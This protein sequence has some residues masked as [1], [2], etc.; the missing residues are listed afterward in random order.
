[1][2]DCLAIVP[3]R[4]GSTELRRKNLLPIGGVP[5]VL[6][7]AQAAEDA[8]CRVVVSTDD[9]EI[10]STANGSAVAN[11]SVVTSETWKD[12]RSAPGSILCE[13]RL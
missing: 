12:N 9:P 10:R 4:G 11:I 6:R 1:M 7:T 5:M 2:T 3:A 13:E 8:G